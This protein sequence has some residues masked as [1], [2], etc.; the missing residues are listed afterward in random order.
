MPDESPE[1]RRIAWREVCPWLIIFKC[2]NISLSIP[3][4]T[5]ATAGWF[6]APCG[7]AIADLLF[8]PKIFTTEDDKTPSLRERIMRPERWSGSA[9]LVS[10]HFPDSLSE[11]GQESKGAI[12]QF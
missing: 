11:L 3:L 6:L 1:L 8:Q 5:L 10:Y 12:Q 9:P 4:L 7:F 2:L